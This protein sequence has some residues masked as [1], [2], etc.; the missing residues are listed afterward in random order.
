MPATLT[1]CSAGHETWNEKKQLTRRPGERTTLIFLQIELL[2]PVFVVE[3][4]R[5]GENLVLCI[6]QVFFFF[7]TLFWRR[8]G[9]DVRHHHLLLFLTNRIPLPLRRRSYPK[10]ACE[11]QTVRLRGLREDDDENRLQEITL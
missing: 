8:L 6:Y 7:F 2:L 9:T 3:K 4:R 1:A 11:A 5:R 10:C